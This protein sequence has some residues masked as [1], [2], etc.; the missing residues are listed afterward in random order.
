MS[1]VAM[2]CYMGCDLRLGLSNRQATQ[3]NDR[4]MTCDK[5]HETCDKRLF[6]PSKRQSNS[7]KQ[8]EKKMTYQPM[9]ETHA[10]ATA[11]AATPATE[12]NGMTG[13]KGA[14]VAVRLYENSKFGGTFAP[15]KYYTAMFNATADVVAPHIKYLLDYVP[16]SQWAN[17]L[18]TP[19]QHEAFD[20]M[21]DKMS[22]E[23]INPE[24]MLVSWIKKYNLSGEKVIIEGFSYYDFVTQQILLAI[25][26]KQVDFHHAWQLDVRACRIKHNQ[27]S[28]CFLA[29]NYD[30]N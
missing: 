7:K 8:K 22:S 19:V 5:T 25:D 24:Q 3:T 28:P 10:T 9:T 2:G 17:S 13:T 18:R 11:T 12:K 1:L 16:Y 29:T 23:N 15:N 4:Q 6:F 30:L 27:K 20:I 26:D 21:R 14:L